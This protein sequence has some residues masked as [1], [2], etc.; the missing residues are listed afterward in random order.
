MGTLPGPE[1]ETL[2]EAATPLWIV[3]TNRMA[4]PVTILTFGLNNI[5]MCLHPRALIIPLEVGDEG[6]GGEVESEEVVKAAADVVDQ[7]AVEAITVLW[8]CERC[9]SQ[10][11]ALSKDPSK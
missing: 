1:A 2:L 9:N 3:E 5:A 7:V 8:A 10:R 6:I 4:W 11:L